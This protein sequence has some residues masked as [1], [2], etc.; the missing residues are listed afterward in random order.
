MIS[1]IIKFILFT[2]STFV[3]F[4]PHGNAQQNFGYENTARQIS[5]LRTA[6]QSFSNSIRS[7][8]EG[9]KN[10]ASSKMLYS[11]KHEEADE[12]GCVEA[13]KSYYTGPLVSGNKTGE[14]CMAAGG[15][16]E[17]IGSK[18]YVC[19]FAQGLLKRWEIL[20][21]PIGDYQCPSGWAQ[22]KQWS[23]ALTTTC[24]G[25]HS[26]CTA[27]GHK[28]SNT[29]PDTC[30]YASY[31]VDNDGNR[32]GSCGQQVTCKAEILSMGCI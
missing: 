22:Y 15:Y 12:E 11:P 20:G 7:D 9:F 32:I 30:R 21:F 3:F 19:R 10:C 5:T 2:A 24:K 4:S 16:A 25:C 31:Q 8:L 26:S 14:D 6:M 28:F 17:D 13:G 18:N 23:Q 27:K 29:R 1:I